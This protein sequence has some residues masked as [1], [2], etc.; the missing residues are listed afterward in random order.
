[1]S[2]IGTDKLTEILKIFQSMTCEEY[3][4]LFKMLDEKKP[5]ATCIT[6]SKITDYG[7]DK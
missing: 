5:F 7:V 4:V 3:D 6:A 2:K 1:M